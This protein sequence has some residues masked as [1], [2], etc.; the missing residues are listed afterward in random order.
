MRWPCHA[1]TNFLEWD[2]TPPRMS[3]HKSL[4]LTV[5]LFLFSAARQEGRGRGCYISP[6]GRLRTEAEDHVT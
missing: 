5:P 3:A 1:A 2:E 4:P 6:F